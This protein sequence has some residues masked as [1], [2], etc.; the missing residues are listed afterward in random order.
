MKARPSGH[1]LFA[2]LLAALLVTCT[3]ASAPP[4]QTPPPP[5]AAQ[6]Q[7]T[8]Q[9]VTEPTPVTAT[10]PARLI[11]ATTTSTAD[12]G[13]LS[14]LLPGFEAR[15]NCKVDVIAVGTG[16]AIKTG[17]SGDCDV[18]LVHARAAEDQFV[19]DG[20]GINRLDVMYNDFVIVGPENDPA[21]I[22]GLTDAVEALRRIAAAEA[23]FVSR[24]DDS[25]THKKEI[26]L[27]QKAE[28]A[29]SGAWY[30]SAGQG[31]GPVL[32]MASEQLAYTLTD[33]ATY[34]AQR[35][36]LDL[37]IVVEGDRLLFNPYGVIAVN[38]EKH[39]HVNSELAAK[40]L[41]WL[42]SLETQEMIAGFGVAEF[43]Q[44]LFVPDSEAW[45]QAHRP[46]SD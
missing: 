36:R 37:A 1:A 31:M 44:P 28:L 16:Q 15:Y 29:P 19:A 43:G 20:Y 38:P 30:I 42:T 26:S 46:D 8:A 45:R 33:R 4:T 35:D 3:P 22:A 7:P 5:T 27:W 17:E 41:S 6:E 2:L 34:L 25:G 14:Y 12:S 24:G 39:P 11:L 21:G 23:R 40:F 32:H 9:P 10:E 18:I 13:L